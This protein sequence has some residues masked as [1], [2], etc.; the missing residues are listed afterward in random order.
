MERRR[1]KE[2]MEDSI[3]AMYMHLEG[4]NASAALTAERK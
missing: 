1:L 2:L 4:G 3:I